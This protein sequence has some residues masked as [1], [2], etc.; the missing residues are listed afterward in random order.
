MPNADDKPNDNPYPKPAPFELNLEPIDAPELDVQIP[1]VEIAILPPAQSGFGTA[2]FWCVLFVALIAGTLAAA[3]AIKDAPIA[4][5]GPN[6]DKHVVQK[7]QMGL[8]LVGIDAVIVFSFVI[9]SACQ[10]GFTFGKAFLWCLLFVV[11]TQGI[12]AILI[13][14]G[15]A[16]VMA[17]GG[18]P[19]PDIPGL[20]KSPEFQKILQAALFAGQIL[21]V[22]FSLVAL[23]WAVGRDWQRKIALRV[24]R[25][26]HVL[27][28]IVAMPALLVVSIALES[29]ISSMVPSLSRFGGVS[30]EEV[31]R[32]TSSWPWSV[33]V[34][35]VGI[36]PALGEEL[37]CR[38]FLGQRLTS[39]Y[40][41][42]GGVLL[43]SFLFGLIHGEPPQAVM[44]F[45][46][47]IVLHVCYLATRSILIPMLMHFLNNTIAVLALSETGPVPIATSLETALEHSPMLMLSAAILVLLAAGMFLHRTR[48][49]IIMS[50]GMTPPRS[51]YPHVET[52]MRASANRA[53][54]GSASPQEVVAL[55][56]SV[57]LF[58]FIWFGV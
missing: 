12:P 44:A 50:T 33:A 21:T 9:Y 28:V 3:I 29:V 46:M 49:R 4:E 16:V 36:G 42:W 52:P 24:P 51:L 11:V 6:A 23:R 10:R 31:V 30:I 1:T 58:A 38:G 26:E 57:G 15:L 19:A 17:S 43:A 37:W 48:V 34:L 25:L 20:L 53:E 22:L 56:V 27:L 5:V 8:L 39:R 45:M 41:T 2:L 14:V 40:G 35:M 7:L 47:G 54:A 13:S 32:A 18:M 55:V